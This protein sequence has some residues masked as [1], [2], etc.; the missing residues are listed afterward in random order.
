MPTPTSEETAVIE[1]IRFLIGDQ[2]GAF[3]D[4]E[5]LTSYAHSG[6]NAYAAA[7]ELCGVWAA[8]VKDATDFDDG[9]R[10]FKDSQQFKHLQDLAARLRAESTTFSISRTAPILETSIKWF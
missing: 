4:D 9:E 3:T 7:A 5:I 1:R 10:T 6:A 8:R 2:S